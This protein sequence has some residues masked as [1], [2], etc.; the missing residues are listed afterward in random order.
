MKEHLHFVIYVI[1]CQKKKINESETIHRSMLF[2]QLQHS[3]GLY[4]DKIRPYLRF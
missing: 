3:I 1:Q 2:Y 4:K